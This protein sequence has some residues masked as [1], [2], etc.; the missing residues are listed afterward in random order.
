MTY[1]QNTPD[2]PAADTHTHTHTHT[3]TYCLV[4]GIYTLGVGLQCWNIH[5]S[6]ALKI[7][8]HANVFWVKMCTD[9]ASPSICGALSEII[10]M[11][12]STIKTKFKR[13]E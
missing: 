8:Y 11:G 5:S 13:N 12:L 6:K 10:K 3:Y 1:K 2:K 9:G 4:S 7:P